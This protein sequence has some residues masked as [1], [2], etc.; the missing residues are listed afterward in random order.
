MSTELDRLLKAAGVTPFRRVGRI[1][2]AF[3]PRTAGRTIDAACKTVKAHALRYV[4]IWGEPAGSLV[5][6]WRTEGLDVKD[7]CDD[8]HPLDVKPLACPVAWLVDRCPRYHF[9]LTVPEPGKLLGVGLPDAEK[10]NIWDMAT[11]RQL[12]PGWFVEAS[13]Q[14]VAEIADH[15][16]A[17]Q[18]GPDHVTPWDQ[19]RANRMMEACDETVRRLK[20]RGDHPALSVALQVVLAANERQNFAGLCFA[21]SEFDVAARRL[22]EETKAV[23][24]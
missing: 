12:L 2:I 11:I 21:C 20:I 9:R 13:R 22:R 19:D 17:E 7:V 24:H 15:V 16:A 23:A 8:P 5:S 18:G 1:R 6:Y 14:R 10:G 3:D 4:D